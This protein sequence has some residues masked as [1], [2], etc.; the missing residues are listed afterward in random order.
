MQK[1]INFYKL[2]KL[3]VIVPA[4]SASSVYAASLENAEKTLNTA[5][6]A[7]NKVAKMGFEWRDTRKA[8][9]GPA[10]KAIKAGD[11]DKSIELAKIALSHAK[12][13]MQ[14]AQLAG[15]A[16]EQPLARPTKN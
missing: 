5:I 3:L 8:L 7:N 15:E 2:L 13:G 1:N 12:S 14:Q 9:L 4:L 16:G 10:Q 6:D 11:Y